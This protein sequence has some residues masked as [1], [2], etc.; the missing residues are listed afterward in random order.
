[1]VGLAAA[2][3]KDP[4]KSLP[5]AAKQ[6]FWRI[7]LFYVINLLIVGLNIPSDDSR[8]LGASGVNV[9]AS[10]FVLAIEEAGIK[11]LPSI[12]NAVVCISVLSVANSSAYGST[13]TLQ[14]MA[15]TGRA[16]KFFAYIDKYGRPTWCI[17][18]QILFG[19]LAFINEATAGST[20][21]DWLLDITSLSGVFTYLSI[22][23]AHLRLRYAFKVQGRSLDEIPWKSPVGII[24]SSIGVFLALVCLLAV[25][26]SSLF[27]SSTKSRL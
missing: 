10:P 3:A 23:W 16:P 26:Y 13:R 4:H 27:V 6:V 1:M 9:K 2:E 25:F 20:V 7:T 21:F 24:G 17:V 18:L 15:M 5:K 8:L 11:V 14:A 12:I 19:F 22:N